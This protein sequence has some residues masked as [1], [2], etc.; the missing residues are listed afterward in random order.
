LLSGTTYSNKKK[1]FW[2]INKK[3]KELL[4]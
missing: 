2:V 4:F 1:K 3:P